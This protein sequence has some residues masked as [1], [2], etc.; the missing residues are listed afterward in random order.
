MPSSI[1]LTVAHLSRSTS[2]FLSALQPLD[3][4][5]RGRSDNTIGFG[6]GSNPSDPTDFWITQEVPGVPAGAA[7]VAFPAKTRAAVQTFFL[8]ALK[9]GG[10]VHGEPTIRDTS[11][12]YSA[13]VI[14]FDG[15]SIEAVYRP[16]FSD[17]KEN[18]TK[19]VVSARTSKNP[20]VGSKSARSNA[21]PSMSRSATSIP[22]ASPAGQDSACAIALRRPSGDFLDNIFDSART[23]ANLARQ[24]TNQ[25]RPTT[26]SVSKAPTNGKG[27]SG[28]GEAIVGTL[29]GVAAGAALHYAFSN[30]N[31]DDGDR[32]PVAAKRSVTEPVTPERW[33]HEPPQYRAIETAPSNYTRGRYITLKDNDYASTVR[34]ASAASHA[35]RNSG[36]ANS[37]PFSEVKTARSNTSQI[38]QRRMIEGSP[39]RTSPPTS[40]RAPTALA[41]AEHSAHA[42]SSTSRSSRRRSLSAQ[43]HSR[44]RRASHSGRHISEEPTSIR[45]TETIETIKS[46]PTTSRRRSSSG[47]EASTV[48]PASRHG[49]K[50]PATVVRSQD[51]EPAFTPL[52]PSRASTWTG[53]LHL[54]ASKHSRSPHHSNCSSHRSARSYRKQDKEASLGGASGL[55]KSVVGKIKDVA[56]L[57]V[58]SDAVKPEDSVSQVSSVRSARR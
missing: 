18:D 13:A 31:N 23:A 15:N 57:G 1:T 50:A 9:A 19:T 22:K 40:Y 24:V 33:Y 10:M 44:P 29:L 53:T 5:Y 38:S 41:T 6:S 47:C 58:S 8:A 45:T 54:S 26:T 21:A 39:S 17:D 48:K 56:R 2:F 27:V 12:Y 7:H 35:R 46:S 25:A 16:S 11:G 55:T 51:Q 43:S 49:N 3:Y 28:T 20:S 32:R 14:D 36:S 37:K 30:C 4:V 42:G 52:P 34:P